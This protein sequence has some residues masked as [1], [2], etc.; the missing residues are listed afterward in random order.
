MRTEPALIIGTV[1]SI[2]LLVAQQVL[3]SGIVTNTGAIEVLGLVISIVPLLSAAI[4]RLFVS[5]ALKPGL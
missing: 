1:F 4:I 2:I 3:D 5:P